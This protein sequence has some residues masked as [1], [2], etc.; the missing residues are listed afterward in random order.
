MED[1][2]LT[3][4]TSYDKEIISTVNRILALHPAP[5]STKDMARF[6]DLLNTHKIAAYNGQ[7]FLIGRICKEEVQNEPNNIA[8]QKFV[9]IDPFYVWR[10]ADNRTGFNNSPSKPHLNEQ[11]AKTEAE[12]LAKANPGSAFGVVKLLAECKV[13]KLTWKVYNA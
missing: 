12:R 8:F 5:L 11:S 1:Q 6:A 4:I 2:A 13:E 9:A 7:L 3:G 10:M